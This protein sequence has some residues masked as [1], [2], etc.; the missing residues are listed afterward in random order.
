VCHR[1][2]LGC[3]KDAF[4]SPSARCRPPFFLPP[5][6]LPLSVAMNL[7][8]PDICSAATFS[9][10]FSL[11]SSP[12]R[13]VGEG[14][15]G[16]STRSRPF[17]P[18]FPPSPPSFPARWNQAPN[19]QTSARPDGSRPFS[20]LLFP[21]L[22]I[23]PPNGTYGA[24]RQDR[25]RSVGAFSLFWAVGSTRTSA[26]RQRA[27]PLPSPFLF[28]SPGSKRKERVRREVPHSR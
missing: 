8:G 28:H 27:R 14:V 24:S 7:P 13:R 4:G 12:F 1:L 20:V 23:V 25:R 19:P 16:A 26:K 2:T 5:L 9:P 11:F 21:P 22:V 10:P 15:A 18:F 17:L 6:P 3:S